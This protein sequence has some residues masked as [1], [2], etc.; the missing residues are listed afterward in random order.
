[1]R[2]IGQH[3]LQVQ[4][5]RLQRLLAREGQQLPDQ[6]RRPIGI[7]MDLHQIGIVGVF[8]FVSQQQ[9]VAVP[10]NRG[11]QVVEIMRNPACQLPDRL[12]L[13]ALNE[14]RF[15]RLERGCIL[16][17]R[18]DAG[19]ALFHDAPQ[20]DL[21]EHL[22]LQQPGA[23]HFRPAWAALA[24]DVI[25]PVCHRTAQALEQAVEHLA[26]I[27]LKPHEA[28][29]RRIRQD[30]R[31]IGRKL[32]QRHRHLFE[33]RHRVHMDRILRHR[34]QIDFPPLARPLDLGQNGP[35][36]T[37][38]RGHLD[39]LAGMQHRGREYPVQ[40]LGPTTQQTAHRL[41]GEQDDA[42]LV[43]GKHR[44]AQ[45][46]CAAP[47]GAAV[48]KLLQPPQETVVADLM[49]GKPGVAAPCH[50]IF[51]AKARMPGPVL[52]P[53]KHRR[54]RG[55]M[56]VQRRDQRHAGIGLEPGEGGVVLIQD[57][58]MAVRQKARRRIMPDQRD[59]LGQS[60]A[61]AAAR[62]KGAQL[63]A[64]HQHHHRQRRNRRP[65][66]QHHVRRQHGQHR[67]T[68]GDRQQQDGRRHAPAFARDRT[69][70][71]RHGNGHISPLRNCLAH[72]TAEQVLTAP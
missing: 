10:R 32:G 31:A 34:Q 45:A 49:H 30:Q 19:T 72:H 21:Q 12:H 51:A 9:Q 54:G 60:G 24:C 35:H 59:Q 39:L 67:S 56:L 44:Q 16:Q 36:R 68:Q 6:R 11:Q 38:G 37:V 26:L 41:V 65:Q 69:T 53:V 4:T 8:A 62:Q 17:H 46:F 52:Q 23:Q 28:A 33:I 29:R 57:L 7:L 15:Q 27:H 61:F 40:P 55:E 20:R 22:A 58:A 66:P 64:Q 42:G 63:Q 18:Q 2:Q 71:T 3:V 13:L 14:L 47:D 50:H 43:G 25:Q 48:L 1:M 5:L 70:Q